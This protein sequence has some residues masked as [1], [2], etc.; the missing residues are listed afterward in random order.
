MEQ[1]FNDSSNLTGLGALFLA[2][3]VTLMFA[4]PRRLAILPIL[5]TVCYMPLG[6]RMVIAGLHFTIVRLLIF[7]GLA[8]VVVRGEARGLSLNR[9]DKLYLWW[10]VLSVI[11]GFL[12]KP[13]SQILVN[14]LGI[15]YNSV[16]IYFLV[17]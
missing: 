16:G 15:F 1:A 5:A 9:I 6:Q 11:L 17:S 12:S 3:T 2:L 10:A 4:L 13:G 7:V 8:R 14:R